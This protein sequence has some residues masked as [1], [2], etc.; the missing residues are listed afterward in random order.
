MTDIRY[1]FVGVVVLLAGILGFSALFT[2]NERD[3]ALVLQFGQVKRLV[4][5][6]GL[7]Y[8]LPW[9]F[10]EVVYFDKRVLDFDA[11][12]EEIP[13]KDQ[14]QIVVDAFARYQII[15]PLLF[16]Q[17]VTNEQGMSARLDKVINAN[18]RAVFGD[19]EL[20]VF[21]TPKRAELM[22]RIAERV[23]RDGKE[24]GVNVLD[25]RLRRVDL[26]EENS[27]AIYRQMQSQREQEARLIR[28]EGDKESRRIRAEADKTA[29]IIAA[30]AE[31]KAN[32]MRGEGDA[33]A[34]ETYN[35]AYGQDREFF[36]FYVSMNAMREGLPGSSTRYVG[37]PEGDFFRFF[38][39][40][41]GKRGGAIPSAK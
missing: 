8:K 11:R 29:Q 1:I 6:S 15:N 39:D 16:F 17:T 9:P 32:I 5:Q 13:T 18:L 33:K 3:Q 37:P 26:P 7:H 25:V 24:F 28:A 21:L 10:Q 34:Q 35:N 22:S 23:K 40:I 38:D 14:K 31:R 20:A 41:G 4:T 27:Q 36:D 12:A 19:F 2:V 30:N